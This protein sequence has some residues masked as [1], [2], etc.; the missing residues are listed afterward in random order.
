MFRSESSG[1]ARPVPAEN[2]ALL[3]QHDALDDVGIFI[4]ADDAQTRLMAFFQ[5]GH[6]AEQDR[7]S[8]VLGDDD[9][10]HVIERMQQPDAADVHALAPSER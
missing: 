4:S 3:Q 9:I 8:I 10:S 5:R 6:I 2:S 7:R 1:A